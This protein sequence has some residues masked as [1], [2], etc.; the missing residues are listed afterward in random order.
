L[1]Y[2]LTA[3]LPF[4]RT[5]RFRAL[6][7]DV[8]DEHDLRRASRLAFWRAFVGSMAHLPAL[9]GV[10]NPTLLV[11]GEREGLYRP[12]NVSLASVMPRAEAWYAPGLGHCWQLQA[13]ELHM[14]TVEAWVSHQDLPSELRPEPAPPT[15]VPSESIGS[16]LARL[17]SRER[18][19]ASGRR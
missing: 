18:I 1:L 2:V 14:R 13:P 16:K 9:S 10:A 8:M 11:A 4:L 15:A 19:E 17:G 7:G 12:S 6:F 3:A 5:R